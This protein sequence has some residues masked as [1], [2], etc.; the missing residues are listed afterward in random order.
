MAMTSYAVTGTR[1]GGPWRAAGL[2]AAVVL[3]ITLAGTASE[4]RGQGGTT[5]PL[6]T[7]AASPAEGTGPQSFQPVV[8]AVLSGDLAALV[9]LVAYTE[10][11]CAAE[12]M[13]LPY[14]PPC[15]DAGV[16]PGSPIPVLSISSCEG[17]FRLAMDV[18]ALLEV[19]VQPESPRVLYGVY[20][21]TTHPDA[22]GPVA[23]V[24]GWP[25]PDAA[26]VIEDLVQGPYPPGLRH[27][28]VYYLAAGT[29]IA[30]R[31]FGVCGVA[32]P[33]PADPAW[34]IPPP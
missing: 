22:A 10:V 11:V 25:M 15:S 9:A 14:V 34:V 19:H 33:D 32:L 20:R 21:P 1:R 30:V 3:S 17:S 26:V 29:I 7:P 24:T 31:S 18:P 12:P 23:A 16:P 4:V 13:G 5:P 8:D 6:S 2:V 28:S 27:G